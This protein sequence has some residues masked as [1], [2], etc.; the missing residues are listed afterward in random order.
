MAL[1]GSAIALIGID[2][3]GA[4]TTHT[5]PDEQ[6]VSIASVSCATRTMMFNS[7][8]TLDPSSIDDVRGY[9]DYCGDAALAEAEYVNDADFLA[10]GKR[11]AALLIVARLDSGQRVAE[12]WTWKDAPAAVDE[13]HDAL[14]TDWQ[15][16]G[17]P[18]D[19]Y[20]WLT[21]VAEIQAS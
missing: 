14:I 5:V 2:M 17:S 19:T 15:A 1:T 18:D 8:A 3:T 12:D 21:D 20:S 13:F 16:A 4:F 9:A 10:A 6:G 11:C 7:C